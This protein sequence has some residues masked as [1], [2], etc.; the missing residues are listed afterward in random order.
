[1]TKFFVQF[2]QGNFTIS[3]NPTSHLVAA[4]RTK[5]QLGV[6]LPRIFSF[7]KPCRFPPHC[8]FINNFISGNFLGGLYI[9]VRPSIEGIAKGRPTICSCL[10]H[11]LLLVMPSTSD[12]TLHFLAPLT[13]CHERL[14]H[15]L[16]SC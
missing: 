4:T 5:S 7:S 14:C 12:L 8:N 10:V 15:F 13:F 16:P 11:A 6:F 1:M 2:L 3:V 9:L